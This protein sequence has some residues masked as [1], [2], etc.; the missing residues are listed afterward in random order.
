MK[1]LLRLSISQT[2]AYIIAS[3]YRNSCENRFMKSSITWIEKKTNG[4]CIKITLA[5]V[6]PW[7]TYPTHSLAIDQTI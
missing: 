5:G 7:I 4:Y 1:A 2:I 6:I 3:K